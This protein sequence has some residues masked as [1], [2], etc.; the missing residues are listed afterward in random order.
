MPIYNYEGKEC[1]E[2]VLIEHPVAMPETFKPKCECGCQLVRYI[3]VD[4][5]KDNPEG[6]RYI[7]SKVF[8]P[9]AVTPNEEFAYKII[10][11]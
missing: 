5:C 11:G 3:V 1:G 9:E 8:V 6:T 2:K 4:K 10:A 7:V